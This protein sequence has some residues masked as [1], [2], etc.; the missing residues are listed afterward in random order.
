MSEPL[1][2]TLHKIKKEFSLTPKEALAELMPIRKSLFIGIPKETAFQEKRIALTPNSVATLVNQGHRVLIEY[3]AGENANFDDEEYLNAGAD[4]AYSKEDVFKAGILLKCAP[5]LPEEISLLHGGQVIFS[6]VLLP[7]MLKSTIKGMMEKKVTALSY[8]YIKSD[9]NH[10]PFT[11]SMGEIAGSYAILLAGKYLSHESGKGILL[12][13]ISGQP[14]CKV[15][16]LGAGAVGEASARA[17]I[18]MGA[19]VQ[20]FDDNI[21]R[22]TRLQNHLGH[23][24]YT[25][26]IDPLNLKKN[27]SRADVLIGAL[28]AIGG[29]T[30]CV[31]SESM[32]QGM[33]KGSVIIDVSIDHGGCV[34]T[35]RVTDHDHPIF[36][37]HGVIHYGVPNIA[38]N[39]ARTASYAMSNILAPMLRQISQTGG[40]EHMVRN[41][42]GLR[43]GTYLY[44]GALTKEFIAQKFDLKFTD[45]ELILSADF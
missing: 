2:S 32:V 4:L 40:V 44:K 24:L 41:H 31:V 8:E 35:S 15:L 43:H 13:G 38:S 26:V 5:L 7:G 21:F 45:L 6:P 17:A 1:E 16:I 30:P 36:I 29:R 10:Y 9:Y 39:V 22:L 23:K 3:G 27:L 37:K 20:V 33:K 11:R 14:P 42:A 12:G 18:G 34:E 19:Q 25:S 28:N